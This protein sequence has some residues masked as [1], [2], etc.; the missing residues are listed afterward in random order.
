MSPND[1]DEPALL[2]PAFLRGL[3]SDLRA[4]CAD[5]KRRSPSVK[6][7]AERVILLLRE[8]DNTE[9][10]RAAADAAAVAFCTACEPPDAS[11]GSAATV[12]KT[13]VVIRAVSC[14]HKLL[15]HRAI[16]V[17]RLPECL[18]AL[19]RLGVGS[20]DDAITLKV[21]QA[22]LALLT[23]R[24]YVRALPPHQLARAVS[25]LFKLRTERSTASA[26][27]AAIASRDTQAEDGVI[28]ITSQAAFRQVASDLF[29]SA[30]DVMISFS[31]VGARDGSNLPPVVRAACGLFQ[32]LCS[33]VA[34]DDLKWL[35][36]NRGIPR[37][38]DSNENKSAIS[39]IAAN[40]QPIHL[41]LAL[42]VMEDGLA[43]NESLFTT[44]PVFSQILS[45]RLCPAVH[46]LL[47]SDEDRPVLKALFG[48]VVTLIRGFWTHL[49]PDTEVLLACIAK[50]ASMDTSPSGSI[51]L[52]PSSSASTSSNHTV[53]W[54]VVYAAEA[55]RSILLVDKNR[56][57]NEDDTII[58]SMFKTFDMNRDEMTHVVTDLIDTVCRSA[59]ACAALPT[60]D[61]ASLPTGPLHTSS[62]PFAIPNSANLA[63]FHVASSAGL[64]LS[65]CAAALLAA[66]RGQVTVLSAMLTETI[67]NSII[68]LLSRLISDAPAASLA[69]LVNGIVSIALAAD[70]SNLEHARSR[71]VTSIGTCAVT[72]LY[73]IDTSSSD[74]A[75]L[76]ESRVYAL[77]RALFAI[78]GV[79]GEHF[80]TNW[81]D[82]VD[83]VQPLDV[84]LY[85]DILPTTD[86]ESAGSNGVT[87]STTPT[88]LSLSSRISSLSSPALASILA[89]LRKELEAA[90]RSISSL[91]WN[92]CNDL[93]AALVVSSRASMAS[94][95]KPGIIS[96]DDE[97]SGAASVSSSSRLPATSGTQLRIFGLVRAEAVMCS[98][99]SRSSGDLCSMPPGL[100][101][102]VSGHLVAAACDSPFP[103]MRST[104]VRSLVQVASFALDAKAYGLVPHDKIISPFVDLLSSTYSDTRKDCV[105]AIYRLLETRGEFL[106]GSDAWS[107]VLSILMTSISNDHEQQTDQEK[108]VLSSDE[109]QKRVADALS[110]DITARVF[111]QDRGQPSQ[112]DEAMVQRGFQAV[113]L[114]ADDFLSFLA[115]ET[116]SDWV[117]VVGAYGQ[118]GADV[119]VALTAV[120][121]LWR[122]AD[123]FAKNCSDSGGHDSLWMKLFAVLKAIGSDERPE[124]R[125]GAVKTLSSTLSAHGSKLNATAWKGCV[126]RALLPL[127][128]EV[129]RGDGT[130]NGSPAARA[131]SSNLR[132]KGNAPVVLHHSRDTPRKQWNETRVLALSG[133]IA[134]GNAYSGQSAG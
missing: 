127:L 92:A 83:A 58:V 102:L 107:I 18:D 53:N 28:E 97:M 61:P 93:V 47:R 101:Q 129:M 67:V 121:L 63:N 4:L 103:A 36:L 125:N 32:D 30:A 55:L 38:P 126:E 72:S 22:L 62:K 78:Q 73:R 9:L 119:N 134:N 29:T 50:I 87:S 90:F 84:A 5:A 76:S 82:F 86:I 81:I 57:E 112:S 104:A 26:S 75:S 6:A 124:V 131:S 37:D 111:P 44:S 48:L 117:D 123:F 79:C 70:K 40:A 89:P 14:V 31:G 88:P 106:K 120:G 113:Q 71:A 91:S 16:P 65:Y 96:A 51:L 77:Y 21:L 12:E 35:S 118:Q 49:V 24:T 17:E 33:V 100:W 15:T 85:G 64:C 122:T 115:F 7:T 1:A 19:E 2:P 108:F 52:S 116:L 68:G 39:L 80:E 95:V 109:Q 94:L 42:E 11:S 130:E 60:T 114:I 8:A 46:E 66:E 99:L 10:S 3:E 56:P 45:S 110:A 43:C 54:A 23:V 20:A 34:G 13:R 25:L 128:E 132:G 41:V 74:A 59:D 98:M 69:L 105:E 133:Y 27:L